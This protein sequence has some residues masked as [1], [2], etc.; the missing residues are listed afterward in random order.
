MKDQLFKEIDLS[1]IKDWSEKDQ[2]EVKKLI[3]EFSFLS[4]LNDLDLGK[5][6]TVKHT[7]KHTDYIPFKERYY[8]I[9]QHQFEKVR[10]HLEEMLKIGAIRCSNSPWA[11]TIVLVQKKDRS[12]KI[13]H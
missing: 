8:R 9:L 13:L 11:N 4:A 1:G 6:N 12:L 3:N 7:I 5:T 2:K 10:K